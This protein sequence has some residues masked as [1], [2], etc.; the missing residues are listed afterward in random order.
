MVPLMAHLADIGYTCLAPYMRGYG[1]SDASPDGRYRPEDLGADAIAL[2]D[3][4]AGD[5]PCLLIGH[6]WGAVAAYAAASIRPERWSHLIAMS[7]PPNPILIRNLRR[8]PTQLRRSWY[9]AFFQLPMIP[10]AVVAQGDL[11]FIERLWRDWSPGWDIPA[12]RLAEVKESLRCPGALSAALGYYRE[13]AQKALVD[14]LGFRQSFKAAMRPIAVPCL[15]LSGERD[16]CIAPTMFEEPG[17]AFEGRYKLVVIPDAGHFLPM[18]APR[19]SF[20]ALRHFI[21]S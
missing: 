14:P 9:L 20:E 4:F 21:E 7:V 13:L 16:G 18:E 3:A 12:Q 6:D 19:A 8:D 11:A 2:A 15:M 5:K 1:G 17:A 10:E